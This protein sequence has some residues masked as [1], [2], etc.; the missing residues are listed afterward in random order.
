LAGVVS[1]LPLYARQLGFS[2]M[3]V[4]TIYTILPITGMLA[5]PIF[6]MMADYFQLQKTLFL[7]CQT[8]MFLAYFVIQFIPEIPAE[9]PVTLTCGDLTYF[10][11]CGSDVDS[12]TASKFMAEAGNS[13]V[14][15]KAT[16]HASYNQ[17]QNLCS[18]W[19]SQKYC[20]TTSST[21]LQFE[22]EIPMQHTMQEGSCLYLRVHEVLF[23]GDVHVPV[24]TNLT[25]IHCSIQC[26]SS[27]LNRLISSP[28]AAG[29]HVA[30][31]YQFWLFLVL[32]IAAFISKAVASTMSDAICFQ[33]LGS[34]P[35]EFGRQR[36]WGAVGWGIF[37]FVA[38][39]LVDKFSKGQTEKDYTVMFYLML[40]LML[41][42][43]VVSFKLKCTEQILATRIMKNVGKLLSEPHIIIFLLWC[44]FVG[45]E[46][47][48]LWQFL[49]WHLEDLVSVKDCEM[50]HWIK[51][52]EG[53]AMGIRCFVGEIPFFFLAGRI[54]KKIGHV[55]AM[56]L[57]LFMFGLRFVLYSVIANPWWSLPL[58]VLQGPTFGIFY[59]TMA[60]YASIVAPPG[61][62]TTMQGVVGAMF[63]GVGLSLGGLLGGV[64]Y[65]RY[66]GALTFQM[67]GVTSFIIFILHVFVQH[68]M[69]TSSR[70][71]TGN[72][73][74]SV[75]DVIT[76]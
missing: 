63:E 27:E 30:N 61:T 19:Q 32:M 22:T 44:V 67:F 56:S 51:T 49:F 1:F 15:C 14:F 52:L 3:V 57:V 9:N 11:T 20:N 24:C 72:W 47:G 18:Y 60:S 16:C 13:T 33:L 45:I 21:S 43:V 55:H 29:T 4:G 66:G 36:L 76:D 10:K 62:E 7:A 59:T 54:L 48:F 17:M 8:V 38:G 34:S 73:K 23:A 70:Y 40:V 74:V 35:Q 71:S 39:V 69:T 28:I 75:H 26:D 58:E 31:L 53:L 6:G 2:S 64:L 42:A 12:C 25:M 41:L 68:L 5:K 46:T 50:Q 65:D 37:A